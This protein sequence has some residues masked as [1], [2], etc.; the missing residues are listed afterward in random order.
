[1]STAP[2][3][4]HDTQ[5]HAFILNQ[6]GEEVRLSYRLQGG[7]QIDFYSTFTPVALRGQGLARVVVDAGIAY[8]EAKQLEII[9]SCSYV[10]KV[11][12][13]RQSAN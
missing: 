8:A 3:V 2:Q 10:A 4:E 7:Q 1:M 12:Q 11:L 5:R 6:D 9:P 13:R